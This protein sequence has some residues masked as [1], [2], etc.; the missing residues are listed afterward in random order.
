[1]SDIVREAAEELVHRARASGHMGKTIARDDMDQLVAD[2][3]GRIPPWL[4]DLL[5]STPL[6]G[7]ELGWQACE[8]EADFDGVRWLE[9]SDARDIRSESVECY[10]GFAIL[11]RGFISIASCTH[12]SGDP[13]FISVDE[14]DD[15]PVYQVYHDV[16]EQPGEIL[17]EGRQLVARSL[18]EFFR[19]AHV[20]PARE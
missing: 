3:G 6:S 5:V 20:E 2:T 15:P 12:G 1:M 19:T 8:P 18:S 9:L 13:Y 11:D 4:A 17:A 10:P 14:G 16:G 7:L